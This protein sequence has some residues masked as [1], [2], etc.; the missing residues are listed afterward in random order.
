MNRDIRKS[1][2]EVGRAIREE[3]ERKAAQLRLE[4]KQNARERERKN[5]YTWK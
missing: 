4:E 2:E 5:G 3:N 1:D